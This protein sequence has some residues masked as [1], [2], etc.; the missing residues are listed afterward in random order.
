MQKIQDALKMLWEHAIRV[1][2]S[3]WPV[4]EDYDTRFRLKVVVSAFKPSQGPGV[5]FEVMVGGDT[6][7]FRH[8]LKAE[9]FRYIQG[10][11]YPWV[12]YPHDVGAMAAEDAFLAAVEKALAVRRIERSF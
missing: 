7:P 12:W 4:G 5:A 10:A 1:I 9:G 6:Y 11:T 2:P 3:P 8:E